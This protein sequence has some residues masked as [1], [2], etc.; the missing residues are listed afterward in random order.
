MQSTPEEVST[1]VERALHD[2]QEMQSHSEFTPAPI[3]QEKVLY[4]VLKHLPFLTKFLRDMNDVRNAASTLV[5]MTTDLPTENLEAIKDIQYVGLALRI[6]DFIRIPLIYLAAFS[7]GEKP[8]FTLANNGRWLYAASLLALGIVALSL[9]ATAPIIAIAAPSVVLSVSLFTLGRLLYDTRQNKKELVQVDEQLNEAQISLVAM[10][11]K[12]SLLEEQLKMAIENKD[13]ALVQQLSIVI[14][15]FKQTYDDHTSKVIQPLID[16]KHILDET[17]KI[18][19]K[20]MDHA[21]GIGFASLTIIGAVT[22]LF[23]PPAGLGILIGTGLA[24]GTYALG[25]FTAPHLSTFA[26]WLTSKSSPKEDSPLIEVDQTAQIEKDSPAPEEKLTPHK[27]SSVHILEKLG[28]ADFV[29]HPQK[30]PQNDSL[31]D[32]PLPPIPEPKQSQSEFLSESRPP[33][34]GVVR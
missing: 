9:P 27:A 12:A 31:K 1:H 6:V 11:K 29:S 8:P 25:K 19:S 14:T 32:R 22:T 16:R 23:F 28:G 2:T 24:S 13:D 26:H 3:A 15:H 17:I 5:N 7:I 18:E 30:I 21:V 10:Q 34:N 4:D 20:M 33:G